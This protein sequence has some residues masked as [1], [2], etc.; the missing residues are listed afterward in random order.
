MK[1][2]SIV[3]F[4]LLLLVSCATTKNLTQNDG[5][6]GTSEVANREEI[7]GN[8]GGEQPEAGA[9]RNVVVSEFIL[10]PSDE[11]EIKVFRHDELN[12]K[13]RIPPDGNISLYLI[14]DIKAAGVGINQL[15]N[16]I[17]EKYLN[18]LVKPE[19]SVDIVALNG[20]KIFVL[21]EVKQPGVY[22]IDPPTSMLE[23]ITKA[24]GFT[25]DGKSSNIVLIRGGPKNPV[26]KMVDLKK[27]LEKGEFGQNVALQ[28]GDVVYVPRTF[29]SQ[30]DRFFYHFENIIRPILWTEHSIVLTPLVEDVFTGDTGKGKSSIVIGK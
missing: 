29:I 10:G 9:E 1:R 16:D 19:I 6:A 13:T 28:T 30:V 17:R 20:Q 25:L 14:G 4:I 5:G 7:K 11:I 15:R 12:K 2:L 3:C 21:G 8:T 23:A 26:A 24:G 22:Q 27:S 18:Y